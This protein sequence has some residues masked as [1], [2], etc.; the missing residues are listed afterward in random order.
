MD[1]LAALALD[2][3]ATPLG[4]GDLLGAL[5]WIDSVP[6]D[7]RPREFTSAL[8]YEMAQAAAV[9]GGYGRCE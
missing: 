5:E 2:A 8:H 1:E 3:A 9:A 7:A 6:I 4:A